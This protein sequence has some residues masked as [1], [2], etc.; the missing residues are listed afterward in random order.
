MNTETETGHHLDMWA[1]E[2]MRKRKRVEEKQKQIFFGNS[3]R[4]G[5]DNPEVCHWIVGSSHWLKGLGK[6][7]VSETG[8]IKAG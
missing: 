1:G 8:Q 2:S 4:Q 6:T 3:G 5:T 7:V